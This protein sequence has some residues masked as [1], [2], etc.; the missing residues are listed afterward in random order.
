[1]DKPGL[2]D[3]AIAPLTWLERAQGWKRRGL[4][5]FYAFTAMV[6][7]LLG[8]R[9]LSLW[10]LPDIGEP[11]DVARLG[12]VEVPDPAN[13]MISYRKAVKDL[14]AHGLSTYEVAGPKA[15]DNHDW[16]T[17]DPEV[18]RWVVDNRKA[19]AAWLEGTERPDSLVVQPEDLISSTPLDVV[20]SLRAFAR[21]ARLEASRLVLEGDLEGAWRLHRASLRSSRHVGM[22]STMVM[23]SMG[24]GI[25]VMGRY[26][27]LRWV[28]DPRVTPA[29]LRRAIADVEACRS[30]TA[31]N[32]EMFRAEYFLMR[33]I[34]EMTKNYPSRPPDNSGGVGNWYDHLTI[35]PMTRQFL[36]REP[37]RAHR[38]HNLVVAGILAQCDRP[39]GERPKL[40]SK[41]YMIFD[42]D[43]RTPATV[44]AI[45]PDDLASWAD[46]SAYAFLANDPTFALS[47]I[48]GEAATFDT[49]L[50]R[51]AERAYEIER[52]RPPRTYGEL[53]GSYLRALPEGI[54]PGDLIAPEPAPN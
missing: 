45:A 8:W 40:A 15:W 54:E 29:M 22:H 43:P 3:W 11:F 34:I 7:G 2:L 35:V 31:P 52:G 5:F 33:S 27:V 37:E 13:A 4:F 51:M 20:V 44:A 16:E 19:F 6:L 1:M 38:V 23:R 53:L 18:R 42:L 30:M 50:L 48:E 41:K 12:K 39:P 47:R 17:A 21:L 46:R 26:D 9:S 36:R 10:Q 14:I 32:S 25:L 28:D 49:Y 24:Q